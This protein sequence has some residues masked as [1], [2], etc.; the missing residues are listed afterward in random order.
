MVRHRF[1]LEIIYCADLPW[2]YGGEYPRFAQLVEHVVRAW[3]AV[4]LDLHF[5]FD[6]ASLSSPSFAPLSGLT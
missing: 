2:V 5:V 4:G 3:I 6:G 1:I